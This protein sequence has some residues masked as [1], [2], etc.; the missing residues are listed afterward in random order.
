MATIEIFDSEEEQE[1]HRMASKNAKDLSE[2]ENQNATPNNATTPR[3]PRTTKRATKTDTVKTTDAVATTET[4]DT[5]MTASTPTE[6]PKPARRGRPRKTAVETENADAAKTEEIPVKTPRKRRTTKTTASSINNNAETVATTEST[7]EPIRP[8]RTRKSS[9][10][11]DVEALSETTEKSTPSANTTQ[12]KGQKNK[13]K[14]PSTPPQHALPEYDSSQSTLMAFVESSV[15][16][17]E[18]PQTMLDMIQQQKPAAE[19]AYTPTSSETPRVLLSEEEKNSDLS[20]TRHTDE[21]AV[22]EGKPARG[23]RRKPQGLAPRTPR[24][25]RNRKQPSKITEEPLQDAASA[26]PAVEKKTVETT[27]ETSARATRDPIETSANTFDEA[28]VSA[29]ADTTIVASS[30][31]KQ[32]PQHTKAFVQATATSAISEERVVETR[33]HAELADTRQTELADDEEQNAKSR[34]RSARRRRAAARK[35]AALEQY[36]TA[37]TESVVAAP[38][39]PVDEDDE[40]DLRTKG[41]KARKLPKEAPKA[42]VVERSMLVSAL[43]G[44]LVE[45]VVLEDGMVAEY[46][47]EMTHH[48]KLRGRIYKGIVSNI[49]TN[50]QAAFVNFGSNKNGF[51]QIDEIHPEYWLTHHESTKTHRYPPIQ[52]VIKPGQEVLVQVV[53]EPNGNKGAFLTTWVSLAGRFLV[54]TPGQEQ[55]GISRKVEDGE[56]R[57][58]LRELIRGLTPGEGLGAIVRTVSMGTSRTTLQKDLDYLKLVW[59]N[60]REKATTENAPALIYQEP[61]LA[62]R[63]VR[64]YFSEDI[65]AIWVDDQE[66]AEAIQSM[67]DL[68]FPEKSALLHLHANKDRT[69]WER[70]DIRRQLDQIHA[71]EV[72]LPSGGRL[73]FDQTEALMAIDINSGKIGGKAN[74]ETMALRTNMEAA[75]TIARQLRLRDIGGQIVID[76]IEMRDPTHTRDVEKTLRNAMKGDRARHDVG[77]MSSFGLLQIVRQRIGSSAISISQESCPHC[78]GTG[79]RRTLEWQALQVLRELELRIRKA[80][81]ADQR[82]VALVLERDLAVYLLNNKRSRLSML[83]KRYN[84]Q[85]EITITANKHP[86]NEH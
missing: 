16:A 71:R 19:T 68:L 61:G 46:Y 74:F 13:T 22:L 14:E 54:L 18:A 43:P 38:V 4:T 29:Q 15:P 65:N 2:A 72:I 31:N 9:K 20:D 17:A 27:T 11:T 39:A 45:V 81:Q 33:Q 23:G 60:I 59:K 50:L 36:N 7:E 64:D 49:D 66:T 6:P 85:V 67:T 86:D 56:E 69:L 84:V 12:G 24:G 47:V 57:N 51:L 21:T 1:A 32:H 10:T 42:P 3:K 80:S 73:V 70:F 37:Q 78:H 44:E 53:K 48:A 82:H 63:A 62:T 26:T 58:R 8:R 52:K 34:S 28:V 83:E 35:K 75:E 40:H 25:G 79:L 5:E 55:I 30:K 41:R 77:K 76:F